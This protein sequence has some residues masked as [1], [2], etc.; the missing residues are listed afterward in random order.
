MPSLQ[1]PRRISELD[2][3][4]LMLRNIGED[5]VSSLGPN[6]KPT[7]QKAQA[8]LAEES[9]NVQSHPYNFCT[10]Q[11][12]KLDPDVNK[13]IGLPQNIL[14]FQPAPRSEHLFLQED[15]GRLYNSGDSTFKFAE[16]VYL[17]AQLAK[18]FDNLPQQARWYIS[19][20]AAIRFAS[21]ENPGSP[22]LRVTSEDVNQA[23]IALEK[24]DARLRRGGLRAHNPFF[25][26]MRGNR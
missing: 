1:N 9:V 16:P 6:A 18:P 10:E 17:V 15:G 26:R 22:S 5:P 24:Y 13:E 12:L 7:A 20:A 19:M 8:M 21:S 2:A 25:Q 4:N 11:A 3:V 23:K 14:A